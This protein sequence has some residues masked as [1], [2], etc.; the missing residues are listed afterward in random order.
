M[1]AVLTS[2]ISAAVTVGA[3][4]EKDAPY[5]AVN[6]GTFG[7][8]NI[9][10]PLCLFGS[11]PNRTRPDCGSRVEPRL[12]RREGDVEH[13]F[14]PPAFEPMGRSDRAVLT[15][16]DQP[17]WK[18]AFEDVKPLLAAPEHFPR[19]R[20]EE[21][22]QAALQKENRLA[23]GQAF[24]FHRIEAMTAIGRCSGHAHANRH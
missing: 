8:R 7:G 1:G 2:M 12:H 14:G 15:F 3:I 4:E 13:G 22:Q 9:H 5:P 20:K 18:L 10:A 19:G 17:Q 24:I 23:E 11:A 6:L 21:R 16:K